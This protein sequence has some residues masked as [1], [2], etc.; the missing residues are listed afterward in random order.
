MPAI[1]EFKDLAA[2]VATIAAA[3]VAAVVTAVFGLAQY[4]LGK[5]QADT[6]KAALKASENKIVLD[7]FEKRWAV[8]SEIKDAVGE[9]AT[10]GTVADESRIKYTTAMQKCKFLFGLEVMT[11]LD[12]ILRAMGRHRVGQSQ[13]DSKHEE[14]RAQG[15]EAQFEAFNIITGFYT[16]FDQLI[17]PYMIMHNKV[18]L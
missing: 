4:R 12:Q 5:M 18:S 15:A 16:E 8:V 11:Y 13:I 17:A 7:L 3:S 10:A 1:C 2:P 14:R 9:V 6:A